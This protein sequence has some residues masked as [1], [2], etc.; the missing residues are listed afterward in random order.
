MDS[1]GIA[2]MVM[3]ALMALGIAAPAIIVTWISWLLV[4][5][6]ALIVMACVSVCLFTMGVE[7]AEAVALELAASQPRC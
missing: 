2:T 6:G 1:T 7:A 5:C 4:V 3:L